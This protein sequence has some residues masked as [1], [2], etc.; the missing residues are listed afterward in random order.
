[1]KSVID[2]Q[3]K[4]CKKYG[5]EWVEAPDGLK[6][7]IAENVKS[8]L[9]PINGLRHPPQGDTTGWYIWAGEEL[10]TDPDFFQPLHVS[11]LKEW[12]PQIMRFLGLPPGWRF[13]L[14]AEYEDV[15]E[16]QSLL[17]I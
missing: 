11:H 1:M 6:I 13:L 4:L 14:A 12:C 3:R 17:E 9:L 7:G 5:A 16:D 15:W 8:G 2:Q 10:S